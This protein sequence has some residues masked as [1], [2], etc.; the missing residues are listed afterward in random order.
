MSYGFDRSEV[1]GA[2]ISILILWALTA[3]LVFMAIERLVNKI[4]GM[5]VFI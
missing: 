4:E 1:L 2:M 5:H 3:V